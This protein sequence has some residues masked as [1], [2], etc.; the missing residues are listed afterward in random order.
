MTADVSPKESPVRKES[1]ISVFL[2]SFDEA[3][4]MAV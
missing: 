1:F 3:E 2:L 4:R